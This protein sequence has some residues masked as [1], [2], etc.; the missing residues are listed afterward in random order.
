MIEN[1]TISN[2]TLKIFRRN[3]YNKNILLI[4]KINI[5]K[6]IKEEYY[7]VIIKV[8]KIKTNLKDNIQKQMAKSILNNL[9]KRFDIR[10][11]KF[12]TKILFYE[13]YKILIIRKT[14]ISEKKLNNNKFLITYLF[15]LN[16]NIILNLDLNIVKI[17]NK[18]NDE[19][20]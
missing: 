9:T 19:E 5:Y 2:L 12:V 6:D 3:Y 4:N 8:Y 7:K 16:L 13:F 10:L 18:Q 11:E 1:L 20:K 17:I 14:I 15:M